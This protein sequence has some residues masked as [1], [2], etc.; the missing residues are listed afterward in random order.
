ME[1]EVHRI[2][3]NDLT[4][5]QFI[6]NFD[7]P[8]EE[9]KQVEQIKKDLEEVEDVFAAN[10]WSAGLSKLAGGENLNTNNP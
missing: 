10:V 6:N 1:N 5:E 7:D 8:V 3:P 2:M 9:Q 4:G